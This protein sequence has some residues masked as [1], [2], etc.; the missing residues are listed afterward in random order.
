MFVTVMNSDETVILA[1]DL[2][3]VMIPIG[4][5]VTLQKGQQACITQSLGGAYT[6]LVNGNLF[7]VEGK[8]AD[9]LGVQVAPKAAGAGA[10]VTQEQLEKEIWDQLRNCYDPEIPV[11]IVDLGL[12]YDCHLTPLGPASYRADVKMTLTAPGCGMGPMLAQD[13][14]NR[15]LGLDGVDDVFVELVWDPPWN[16]AMMSEAAKLQLGLM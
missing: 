11:N 12:I 1:R 10:P 8:D 5:K 7:R 3:A 13:V 4:S 2:E 14:Q 15:L 6:V 9:A 16:Q